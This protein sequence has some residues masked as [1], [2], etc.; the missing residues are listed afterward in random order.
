M[1]VKGAQEVK[2]TLRKGMGSWWRDVYIYRSRS[3]PLQTK[4]QRVVCHVFSTALNGIFELEVD[5]QHCA[6]GALLGN[7]VY[8]IDTPAKNASW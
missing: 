2:K 4:C 6:H 1:L 5:H 7:E 8:A 3:V